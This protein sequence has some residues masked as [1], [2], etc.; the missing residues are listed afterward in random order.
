M[1]VY[2]FKTKAG[3][4]T[5][6]FL[7]LCIYAKAQG[8]VKGTITDEKNK[9][10]VNAIIIYNGQNSKLN[11]NAGFEIK[12]VRAGEIIT[13]K[14]L[15]YYDTS[16]VTTHITDTI[17][18][19]VKLRVKPLQLNEVVVFD[20]RIIKQINPYKADFILDFEL[21][22][23][24]TIVELLSSNHLLYIDD[25]DEKTR[26]VKTIVKDIQKLNT[27]PVDN[28]L[29]LLNETKAYSCAFVNDSAKVT[30]D[31]YTNVKWI[32]NNVE[33]DVGDSYYIRRY[34]ELNQTIGF[35]RIHDGRA[36]MLKEISNADRVYAVKTHA[37]ITNRMVAKLDSINDKKGNLG[38]VMGDDM[39]CQLRAERDALRSSW[40]QEKFYDA[41][42]YNILKE[43]KD[44][45]FIFAHDIDSILVFTKE[46]RLVRG[47]Y[48][49]YHHLKPWDKQI[50]INKEKTKAYG[51]FKDKSGMYISEIDLKTG[52]LMLP[53]FY[54]EK[55]FPSKIEIQDNTIYFMAK[56]PDGIGNSLYKLKMTDSSRY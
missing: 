40:I 5:L 25:V 44:S 17:H 51:K 33:A 49:D 19:T 38:G 8:I 3:Y 20:N 16:L 35:F 56:Q 27:L 55:Q 36:L 24:H 47:S 39:Q 26:N 52:K 13:I 31:D 1:P 32:L 30:E 18:Y 41:P 50:I 6:C 4:L 54:I 10:L 45:I 11:T 12:T 34:K 15:G 14:S 42:S 23:N 53:F 37:K 7:M 2:S 22:P 43:I 46:G 29:H 48:I 9:P 28:L 21:L